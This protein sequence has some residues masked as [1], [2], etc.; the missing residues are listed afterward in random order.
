VRAVRAE[1]TVILGRR[2]EDMIYPSSSTL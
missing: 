2:S 1:I